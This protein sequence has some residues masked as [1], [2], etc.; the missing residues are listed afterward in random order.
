MNVVALCSFPFGVVRWRAPEPTLTAIVKVTL[1]LDNNG[2]ASLAKKQ[3]PLSLDR[4]RPAPHAE[5]SYATDFAPRK[6]QAD[7]LLVGHAR[8]VAPVSSISASF[9]VGAMEKRFVAVSNEPSQS[10]P[11]VRAH[12]RAEASGGAE[13]CAVG[14]RDWLKECAGSPESALISREGPP[15][16]PLSERFSFEVFNAAPADQRVSAIPS[17]TSIVLEG[18]LPGLP[19]FEA[20]LP[21]IE[22]TVFFVKRGGEQGEF[23]LACDTLY[24]D[25]DRAVCIL[26]FRGSTPVPDLADDAAEFVV[27]MRSPQ[28][29]PTWA[30][31]RGVL[32]LSACGR[33]V[34]AADLGRSAPSALPGG[35]ETA[36]LNGDYPAAGGRAAQADY[37]SDAATLPIMPAKGSPPALVVMEETTRVVEDERPSS[38]PALP[39]Q[40]IP[41]GAISPAAVAG[42]ARRVTPDGDTVEAGDSRLAAP[43]GAPLPFRAPAMAQSWDD[44]RTVDIAQSAPP[45]GAQ[46]GGALPFQSTE[47]PGA[48]PLHSHSYSPAPTPQPAAPDLPAAPPIG[49]AGSE[50][51][52]KGAAR[53]TKRISMDVFAAIHA[54]RWEGRA[55]LGEILARY[56]LDEE[57][58]AAHEKR[59]NEALA[60]EARLGKCEL[61]LEI[62]KALRL[63]RERVEGREADQPLDEYARIR[64]AVEDAKDPSG[65]LRTFGLSPAAWQS[66]HRKWQLRAA[67]DP[68]AA[69]E[70]RKAL[71]AAR[72]ALALRPARGA[73][74]AGRTG[75]KR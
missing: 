21:G 4:P 67:S 1:S 41:P 11:L 24:I 19:R 54:E 20:R 74:P 43:R 18:L 69:E 68:A 14:P 52:K 71:A 17:D 46:P 33:A 40:K 58:W 29:R 25:T 22:P 39:F 59:Q 44:E 32:G 73:A 63:A 66:I 26:V 34:E 15:A 37:D 72:K 12:L 3:D 31:V 57:D 65:A 48:R 13:P 6:A 28:M 51:S 47:P 16:G 61:A 75:G 70:L 2:R 50:G 36:P 30:S 5:L 42:P 53:E 7:I 60:E 9:S 8:A 38:A 35:E 10:I 23:A 64:A 27:V 55:R 49:R 56:G 62:G 45:A